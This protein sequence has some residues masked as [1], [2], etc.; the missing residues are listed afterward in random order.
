MHRG[1]HKSLSSETPGESSRFVA[2][3]AALHA[4]TGLSKEAPPLERAEF[5][6]HACYRCC[7]IEL[8]PV[9]LLCQ[10]PCTVVRLGMRQLI[11]PPSNHRRVGCLS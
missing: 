8:R 7:S 11:Q 1:I 3:R 9:G 6:L 2:P 5:D 4:Q 10:Q